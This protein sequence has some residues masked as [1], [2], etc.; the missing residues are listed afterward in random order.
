LRDLIEELISKHKYNSFG[1][2]VII[3]VVTYQLEFNLFKVNK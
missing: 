1:F 2:I 3:F